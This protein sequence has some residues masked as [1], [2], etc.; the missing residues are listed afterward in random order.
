MNTG[1]Y[2]FGGRHRSVSNL[3][4]EQR[5]EAQSS[6]TTSSSPSSSTPSPLQRRSRRRRNPPRSRN[7]PNTTR[8]RRLRARRDELETEVVE[9]IVRQVETE[10]NYQR[11]GARPKGFK[12]ARK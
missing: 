12:T 5:I 8:R 4:R 6:S 3:P 11:M 1:I 9:E 7:S 10:E 2:D